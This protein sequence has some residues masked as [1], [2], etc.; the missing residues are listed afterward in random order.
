MDHK[1]YTPIKSVPFRHL[2]FILG[3][4]AGQGRASANCSST[5]NK[6]GHDKLAAKGVLEFDI[7]CAKLVNHA[8]LFDLLPLT[9]DSRRK[10]G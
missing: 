7:L 5:M 1:Y 8:A 2:Y 9:L 4:H 6:S 10:C 3:N